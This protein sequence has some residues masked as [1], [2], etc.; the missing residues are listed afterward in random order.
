MF[1]YLTIPNLDSPTEASEML[2][3]IL[4]FILEELLVSYGTLLF[5][6]CTHNDNNLVYVR[7][8]FNSIT[9]PSYI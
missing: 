9:L 5:V 3:S 4:H 1:S 6:H 8:N 2:V 7:Y